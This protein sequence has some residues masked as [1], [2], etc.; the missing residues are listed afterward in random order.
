MR[1]ICP[2]AGSV[3]PKTSIS[4]TRY[5]PSAERIDVSESIYA[6]GDVIASRWDGTDDLVIIEQDNEITAN[7][8]SSFSSCGKPWCVYVYDIFPMPYTKATPLGLGCTKFSPEA[9]KAI[10]V[11]D[12]I[13][14]DPDFLPKC[15]RCDGK[16]CWIYLDARITGALMVKGFEY[17]AHGKIR[18]HHKYPDAKTWAVDQ[19]KQFEGLDD[20]W[21]HTMKT[22]LSFY[23]VKGF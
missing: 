7:V 12:F 20:N 21:L 19:Y 11:S 4:L 9:Q 5:A 10:S 2:Y 14:P 1:V 13:G 8:L 15:K 18:H 6:Y 3:E 16:G 23:L 22:A 17:H